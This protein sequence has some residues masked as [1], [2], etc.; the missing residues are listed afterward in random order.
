[1][2]VAIVAAIADIAWIGSSLYSLPL[3]AR[4]HRGPGLIL[5]PGV[6]AEG[7][8]HHARLQDK[9]GLASADVL[10]GGTSRAGRC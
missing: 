5:V 3:V 9:I 4:V 7:A 8:F 2:L 10:D 1:M 6:V